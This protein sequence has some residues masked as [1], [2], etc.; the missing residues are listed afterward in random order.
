LKEE[1]QNILENCQFPKFEEN[2]FEFIKEM[3]DK[4]KDIS[5]GVSKTFVFYIFIFYFPSNT[6]ELYLISAMTVLW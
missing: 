4:P 2:D 3:I 5:T 6:F 1:I